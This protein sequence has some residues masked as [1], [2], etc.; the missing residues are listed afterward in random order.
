MPTTSDPAARTSPPLPRAEE[1]G[2]VPLS[3]AAVGASRVISGVDGPARDELGREGLLPGSVVVVR[4][5]TPLGGPIVVELGRTRLALS[6]D[7]AAGV[8]TMPGTAAPSTPR[9][10]IA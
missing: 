8:I 9:N 1:D 4:A 3:L 6:A 10:P 2:P 7:V 5:R